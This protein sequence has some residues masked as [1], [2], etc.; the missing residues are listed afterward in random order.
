MTTEAKGEII[1]QITEIGVIP[2]VRADSAE[3]AHRAAKAIRAGGI[4]IIE[5]TMTVPGAIEIIRKLNE[6]GDSDVL[7]GA[8]TVLNPSVARD[9]IGAG[10]RFIVS[11]SMNLETIAYCKQE[12]VVVMPGALTPSEI[13][14]AWTAGAD[15]VK[16]FPAGAVG[17]PTYIRS[18]KA[19]LP[20][21]RLVPTGG[22]SL[23]NA[24]AFI[25]AGAEAVGVGGELVDLKA[26]R[27][28]KDAV[29]TERARRILES[30][31]LGRSN[32]K[33][34]TAQKRA[35]GGGHT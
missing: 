16:I 25:E 12:G 28:G 18:V 5:I 6:E 32:R 26:L 21:I 31:K 7:V 19:P 30:V 33:D 11:P 15:F 35:G 13:V 3:I 20:E 8:G 27:E 10:A 14:N 29:V 24:A 2:V 9:C 4:S 23:E 22:V 34:A 1:R 17:G